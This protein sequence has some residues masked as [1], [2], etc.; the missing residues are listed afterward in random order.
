MVRG[1]LREYFKEN[2]GF[3]TPGGGNQRVGYDANHS[4]G[5]QIENQ[6][7]PSAV[8]KNTIRVQAQEEHDKSA[9]VDEGQTQ[10]LDTSL[11][12]LEETEEL[13]NQNQINYESP[14]AKQLNRSASKSQQ[15][16]SKAQILSQALQQLKIKMEAQEHDQKQS[17]SVILAQH[18]KLDEKV[19]I[20]QRGQDQ[21]MIQ[22][23]AQVTQNYVDELLDQ[24]I[25]KGINQTI[26]NLKARHLLAKPNKSSGQNIPRNPT[27]D[28][29]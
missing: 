19:G 25:Q 23:L 28:S 26:K 6:N 21:K 2:S 11:S 24:K 10:K 20:L 18:F 16:K 4:T 29:D 1:E 9:K 13:A 12:D 22:S 5:T 3:F 7:T 8:H 14:I 17:I 27:A 15:K